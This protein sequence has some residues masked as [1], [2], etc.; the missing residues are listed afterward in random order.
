MDLYDQVLERLFGFIDVPRE[1]IIGIKHVCSSVG[2]HFDKSVRLKFLGKSYQVLS[3]V[4]LMTVK[5]RK[6]KDLF[7]DN[8]WLTYMEETE[9]DD[10]INNSDVPLFDLHTIVVATA[11]FSVDNKLGQGG[12]SSVYKVIFF[13]NILNAALCL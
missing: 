12:F 10:S 9:L 3:F 11:N 7:G 13:S 5:E 8:V 6:S 2:L 1:P 4:C